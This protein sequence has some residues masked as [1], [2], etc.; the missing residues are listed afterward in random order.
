MVIRG[1]GL[2]PWHSGSSAHTLYVEF[3]YHLTDGELHL[4]FVAF[5]KPLSYCY[6]QHPL[7]AYNTL[8]PMLGLLHVISFN[9]PK[10]PTNAIFIFLIL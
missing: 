2:E 8:G 1:T 3:R 7:S 5:L 6:R 4:G 9:L 10:K